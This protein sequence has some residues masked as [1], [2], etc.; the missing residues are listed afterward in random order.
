MR[1]MKTSSSSY[2][3]RS[4]L[5][6]LAATAPFVAAP[7][8]FA[9]PQGIEAPAW[10]LYMYDNFFRKPFKIVRFRGNKLPINV[11]DHPPED[12]G[13]AMTV[14]RESDGLRHIYFPPPRRYFK[15]DRARVDF[16]S[17][18]SDFQSWSRMKVIRVISGKAP[19]PDWTTRYPSDSIGYGHGFDKNKDTWGVLS[20]VWWDKHESERTTFLL[21][22]EPYL[23]LE[24]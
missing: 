7:A 1:D 19:E 6:T 3:R 20:D 2:S 15:S 8:L 9:S 22:E 23:G 12:K 10:I 24:A 21:N 4:F 13:F 11:W 5:R 16:A 14:V 17:H 18:A